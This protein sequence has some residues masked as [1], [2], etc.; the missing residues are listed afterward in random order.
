MDGEKPKGRYMNVKFDREKE[1]TVDFEKRLQMF[2]ETS[3]LSSQKILMAA[4]MAVKNVSVR[5][6]MEECGAGMEY[7]SGRF[8]ASPA[9]YTADVTVPCTDGGT[10]K[11]QNGSSRSIVDMNHGSSGSIVDMILA[12]VEEER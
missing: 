4:L 7:T 6:E 1:G 10:G 3:G 8:C 11:D 12:D 9:Q 2:S 5:V